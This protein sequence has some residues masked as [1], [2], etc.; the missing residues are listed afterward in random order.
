VRTLGGRY[1]LEQRI[2]VGGMSEVW[3]GYDEVLGR[4]V[5]VKLLTRQFAADRE[6]RERIRAEA[7]MAARLLHPNIA[8]VYD[9]GLSPSY[10]GRRAPYIV[11]ELVGGNSLAEHL[12]VG[13]MHWPIAARICAE[14][15]AALAAAHSH[16]V[17]HRDVKPANVMLTPAGTKVLD[18]GIAAISGQRE[19]RTDGTLLGTPAYVAPERLRGAKAAPA[20][21]MYALGVLLHHCLAG[22]LPWSGATGEQLLYAQLHTEPEPLPGISGLA[23]EVAEIRSACLQ[24][25]PALRPT[26]TV[27]ALVLA[28]AVDAR[29]YVP[30]TELPPSRIRPWTADGYRNAM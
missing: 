28:E 10:L 3:R 18:F 1:R 2:G 19:A 11:M 22:R 27:A 12:A 21:D 25:E 16:G 6:A 14:V 24:K 9:F 29:V 15:S 4:T 5:A 26:S 8:G 13:A 7:R 20:S 17:V 23:P 30:S